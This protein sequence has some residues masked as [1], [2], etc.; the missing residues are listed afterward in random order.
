MSLSP[1]LLSSAK[2]LSSL[3]L[4][5]F[6]SLRFFRT[7]VVNDA[8]DIYRVLGLK[9]NATQREIKEAFYNLSKKHHP[10]ITKNAASNAKFQEILSAYEILG[11]PSRRMEYDRGLFIPRSSAPA[12]AAAEFPL[13]D[14]LDIL[15]KFDSGTFETNYARAYNRN[16]KNAWTRRA[17]EN[18][19]KSAFDYRIDQRKFVSVIYAVVFGLM[20]G[21]YGIAKCYEEPIPLVASTE[22]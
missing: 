13:K 12:A 17:D 3:H 5:R 15:K 2:L 7:S 4:A 22:S 16:L 10:D 21:S 18:I 9:H 11:D 20:A 8:E 14:D 1:R 19:S 6:K